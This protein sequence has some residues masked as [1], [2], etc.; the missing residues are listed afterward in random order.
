MDID[1]QPPGRVSIDDAIAEVPGKRTLMQFLELFV[2]PEIERRRQLGRVDDSFLVTRAQ[3]VLYPD[4]RE[5]VIRF[6]DEIA[7][8][9]IARL[10]PGSIGREYTAGSPLFT[11]EI[12]SIERFELP[13]EE[14]DAGHIT[15]IGLHDKIALFFDARRN[16]GRASG[17]LERSKQFFES[18][19]AS[20]AKQHW[21]V[22]VDNLFSAAELAVKAWLWT[23][24]LGFEFADRMRHGDIGS[25]FQKYVQWGNA[26]PRLLKTYQE[27]AAG[28]PPMRYRQ[29]PKAVRL[30][31]ARRW[32]EDV[33]GMVRHAEIAVA[34]ILVASDENRSV[35]YTP[36]ASIA[37]E[38]PSF[39]EPPTSSD[40]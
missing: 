40:S 29:N 2:R 5:P 13:A 24:P 9:A 7:G 16:R 36:A 14:A 10:G 12:E 15:M 25:A 33:R 31:L 18:A 38:S 30:A 4:G 20:F 19:E 32:L 1:P 37:P 34:S 21:A 35:I 28:R 22:F 27:L 3:V 26:N 11:H 39:A 23:G 6:N 17:L 8:M